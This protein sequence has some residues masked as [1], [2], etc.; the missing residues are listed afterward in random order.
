MPTSLLR[1]GGY[2]LC[3]C[4]GVGRR[5]VAR[6]SSQ[7]DDASSFQSRDVRETARLGYVGLAD[8]HST[9]L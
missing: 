2:P 5:T 1:L 3:A 8:D 6:Y 7:W 9:M 4:V